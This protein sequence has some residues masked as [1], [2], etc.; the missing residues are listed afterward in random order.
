MKDFFNVTWNDFIARF[1]TTHLKDI[2]PEK[3]KKKCKLKEAIIS[4]HV[5]EASWRD[6]INSAEQADSAEEKG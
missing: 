1:Q 5:P 6:T 4:A 2:R 3:K